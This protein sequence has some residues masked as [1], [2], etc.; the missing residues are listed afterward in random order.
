MAIAE[1]V[2]KIKLLAGRN[3]QPGDTSK[4]FLINNTYA[5]ILGF[6]S[7][8]DAIGKTFQKFNGQKLMAVVGVVSDF[9]QRT[10][11]EPIKPLAICASP[12]R[13]SIMHIAL[14]PQTAN[15]NE[16]KQAIAAMQ[17]SWKQLYPDDDF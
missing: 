11:H 15:G 3:L 12:N 5:K 10:L 13:T 17:S 1:N 16:W 9:Y 7:P 2:Y 4:G 6:K 8:K 14:K